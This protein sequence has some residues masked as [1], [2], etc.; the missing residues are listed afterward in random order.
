[1]FERRLA[2]S[3][4]RVGQAELNIR[5]GVEAALVG[6]RIAAP[7][8]KEHRHINRLVG[9]SEQIRSASTASAAPIH[10]KTVAPSRDSIEPGS[11]TTA[12]SLWPLI[13]AQGDDR[14]G[15]MTGGI[16]FK[17]A[18]F[19]EV[20][21][22]LALVEGE[23]RERATQLVEELKATK[24]AHAEALTRIMR[25]RKAL[26]EIEAD[27][28]AELAEA[29][30]L[31]GPNKVRRIGPARSDRTVR[32]IGQNAMKLITKAEKGN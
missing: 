6:R 4:E 31:V 2:K 30:A 14:L 20:L 22:R 24:K 5:L 19:A 3:S 16:H 1:M 18:E 17:D 13:F 10:Q 21:G 15:P 8:R 11:G 12:P 27:L 7:G 26:A 23:K 9:H 29:A 28:K 32:A 25:L